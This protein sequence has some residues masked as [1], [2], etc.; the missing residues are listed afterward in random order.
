MVA[1]AWSVVAAALITAATAGAVVSYL[2][3]D[4]GVGCWTTSEGPRM[5]SD[6][7]AYALPVLSVFAL[8]ACLLAALSGTVTRYRNRRR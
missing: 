3:D 7:S 2:R 4:L 8:V 5:C 6:G 1:I